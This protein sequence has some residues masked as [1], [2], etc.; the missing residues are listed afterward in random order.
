MNRHFSSNTRMWVMAATLAGVLV[1]GG[2]HVFSPPSTL[3]ESE[4]Q[5]ATNADHLLV[6]RLENRLYHFREGRLVKEYEVSTGQD[7]GATPAGVFYVDDLILEPGG[8]YGTRWMGLACPEEGQLSIGIHGTDEPDSI[9]Q[10]AS[11]GCIRMENRQA[12]ELFEQVE[13]GLMVVIR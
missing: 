3:G 10:H 7:P 12:E 1:L 5:P 6:A 4:M 8:P 11:A 2:Y 9:G 13:A